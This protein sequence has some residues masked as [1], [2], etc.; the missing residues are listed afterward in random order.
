[1]WTSPGPHPT[2]SPRASAHRVPTTDSS[3]TGSGG[4]FYQV[5]CNRLAPQGSMHIWTIMSSYFFC[6]TFPFVIVSCS[7]QIFN[8][9]DSISNGFVL[10]EEQG[11]PERS[12]LGHQ[13]QPCWVLS[14]LPGLGSEWRGHQTP[15]PPALHI[16]VHSPRSY[17]HPSPPTR[18]SPRLTD[19]PRGEMGSCP[20]LTSGSDPGTAQGDFQGEGTTH[21]GNSFGRT[22]PTLL[23]FSRHHAARRPHSEAMCGIQP[24]GA[25]SSLQH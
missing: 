15:C 7:A 16:A 18:S 11:F 4:L 9:Q 23:T 20:S 13:C 5:G 25:P 14:W 6:A 19:A 24:S 12:P 8:K 1:M 3:A 22:T 21:H 10:G 17:V 2:P